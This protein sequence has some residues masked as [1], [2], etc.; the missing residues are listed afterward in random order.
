MGIISYAHGSMDV[1][2][3]IIFP[4]YNY[5]NEWN[6]WWFVVFMLSLYIIVIRMIMVICYEMRYASAKWKGNETRVM[7]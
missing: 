5:V 1:K 2:W 6:H 3:M 7:A 4:L